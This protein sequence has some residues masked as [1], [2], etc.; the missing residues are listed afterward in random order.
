MTT[1]ISGTPSLPRSVF[2]HLRVAAALLGALVYVPLAIAQR[3]VP[4]AGGSAAASNASPAARAAYAAGLDALRAGNYQEAVSQF[5]RATQNSD[6]AEFVLSRGV[7]LVLSDQYKQALPDLQRAHLLGLRSREPELW[8]YAAETMGFFATRDHVIGGPLVLRDGRE[9][10]DGMAVSVPG[11][12]VQGGNDYPTAYASTIIYEMAFPYDVARRNGRQPDSAAAQAAKLKAAAAFAD[13]HGTRADMAGSHLDRGKAAFAKAD[14][15]SALR[16]FKLA[17]A[18]APANGELIANLARVN[19]FYGRPASARTD[20][21]RALTRSSSAA[22][23]LGRSLAAAQMGDD[24]RAAADLNTASAMDSAAAA[25]WRD[26][27]RQALS[28]RHSN[29]TPEAALSAL[30]TAA[31]GTASWDQLIALA[32]EVHRADAPHR[33]RYDEI[34]EDR[35]R[36]LV[37]AARARPKDPAPLTA[38]AAYII[39]EA[40]NKGDRVEPRS[41]TVYY[42]W[43]LSREDDLANGI[44]AATAALALDRRYAPA[45]I[46]EALGLS[47]LRRYDEAESLAD[48][49]LAINPND[50]QALQLY[51]RFRADRAADLANQASG[52][53]QDRCSSS[54]HTEDRSDGVYDVTETTCYPPTAGDLARAQQLDAQAAELARR[55]QG[56]IDKALRVS[57][58][59]IEGD[60]LQADVAMASG[61]IKMAEA[62]L[63]R[64][65]SKNPTS[66]EAQERLADLYFKSGQAEQAQR[67]LAV[68]RRLVQTTAAPMLNLAWGSIQRTAWVAADDILSQAERFDITDARVPAYRSIVR[69][70]QGRTADAVTELKVA[71][72]LDEARVREDEPATTPAKPLARDP[73]IFAVAMEAR[74]RLA[75]MQNAP[76]AAVLEL[77]RANIAYENRVPQPLYPTQMFGA[78][79][80]DQQPE[81]G[82]MVPA[83]ANAATMISRSRLLAAKAALSA[84]RNDEARGYLQAAANLGYQPG[85]PRIAT[86]SG[87]SNFSGQAVGASGDA[88]IELARLDM[89]EG[90][91]HAAFDLIQAA[92]ENKP[93]AAGRAESAQIFPV[94]LQRLQQGMDET[95]GQQPQQ[96]SYANQRPGPSTYSNQQPSGYENHQA[97]PN[98]YAQSSYYPQQPQQQ[99]PQQ[100]QQRPSYSQAPPYSQTPAQAPSPTAGFDQRLAGRWQGMETNARGTGPISLSI[101]SSGRY[102]YVGRGGA[103][104]RMGN[105]NTDGSRM[106]LRNDH[107]GGEAQYRL[108]RNGNFDVLQITGTGTLSGW[109]VQLQR[110]N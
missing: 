62:T 78:M 79:W 45:L 103:D 58:G 100:S 106:S 33:L 93:S 90:K 32:G 56:A 42:R 82:S 19:L 86:G 99:P 30:R 7:A 108:I 83:P 20:F 8:T 110:A 94:V 107:G 9:L 44:R 36:T 105:M 80:P 68:A 50:T 6:D 98:A 35:I 71:I 84:G 74:L 38:F 21:T 49:A 5:T 3:D 95:R 69:A 55:A 27:I 25:K 23:Y 16:E 64:I 40:N 53:R 102:T 104:Q 67:Q 54:M 91:N 51:A 18:P 11:N 63:Q 81:G 24:R 37:A 87:D 65:I 13:L 2:R 73:A 61:N 4:S 22:S 75:A 101:D 10:A 46:Q 15:Q 34:Y 109:V 43:Q 47:A 14:Y 96:P 48:Q 17:L 31:A 70:G 59:T 39:A 29:S 89:G 60:L 77:L 97:G 88:M 57:A 66:L 12:M 85:T 41:G 92:I 76:P 52:A 1:T 28:H 72:A 26:S